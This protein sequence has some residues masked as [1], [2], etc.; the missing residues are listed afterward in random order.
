MIPSRQGL[1]LLIVL[2]V[3]GVLATLG[4]AFVTMAQLERK[5]SQQRLLSTKA[6]ML[7]RSGLED[8][9]ARLSAGQDP[10]LAQ[11]AYGGENWDGS[12]DGL[13]SAFEADQQ[14]YRVT[15]A[16][17]AADTDSC[18]VRQALR[19]SFFVSALPSPMPATQTLDGRMRG[20]SGRLGGDRTPFGN[21]YAL[22]VAP[23]GGFY[24]NGGDPAA[25]PSAGYNAV[26][27]RMLGTLAEAIDRED[28]VAGNGPLSAADGLNL[29]DRRPSDGW[30]DWD[31]VR[32]LA[33]GGDPGKLGALK[34]YLA[35][36]AWVDRK[37]IAPNAVEPPAGGQPYH[38]RGE[39]RLDRPVS[40]DGRA[41]AFECL[42]T[43]VVGRAPVDLAWA[44]TRRPA[45]V[46]LFAGLKGAYVDET[47]A[48]P[49]AAGDLL[50]KART[51]E[52]ANAWTPTDDC[53]LA[54]DRL[55]AC[56]S[57][58]T[59]W[60]RW[61]AFCDAIPFTG[62]SEIIQAKRDLLKAN[63]NPNSDLNKFSPNA[64]LWRSVDKSDLLVYSTEFSLLPGVGA[65]EVESAGRLTDPDGRLLASR[66]LQASVASSSRLTLTTQGEFVCEELGEPSLAGD[67]RTVR[68]PGRTPFITR[69]A[70]PGNTR[71]W[72]HALAAVGSPG[73]SLQTY[74]EPCVD[75]G[76]G[77]ELHPARYD[78]SV[79]LATLETPM[80]DMYLVTSTTQDMK[81][82][83]RYTTGFDLDVADATQA[84]FSILDGNKN[85]TDVQ[86]VT[87]AELGNGLLDAV[88]PNTL[89]P[90]GVYAERDRCPAYF[91][92]G[93]AH[94]AHGLVS[95]WIK[96][97]HQPPQ[98]SGW[99]CSGHPFLKRT[100]AMND[101]LGKDQGF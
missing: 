33:L 31:Q 79:Q 100:N 23:Q 13:L 81:L 89:H 39:V 61:S 52:L 32:T 66:V 43:R 92:L 18:P 58:L 63:F 1:A 2:G 95:F 64:S 16:G 42:G 77:L 83:A 96:S 84:P 62:T 82:L 78:G 27:R 73:I 71:T 19:P 10:C 99:V 98:G 85:Q 12:A 25:L 76:S 24:L 36:T 53:H 21:L 72:G 47:A 8:A 28:G 75:P 59:T 40:D 69:S 54:V 86:Q 57:E 34:P 48:S 87:P 74:P 56:T 91:D 17:T 101:S 5:A 20:F 44:R 80:D 35:L 30:R 46:A 38:S 50:G 55:L 14:L 29:V 60:D 68:L 67:E 94:P 49:Q 65:L 15:P 6:L 41:P 51:A 90:D 88:K 4:V 22:K 26:L 3:L 45:L 9:Q 93:N 70:G 97:D 37:V 7:A 11:N